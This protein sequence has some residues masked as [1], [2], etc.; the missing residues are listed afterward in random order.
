MSNPVVETMR[1]DGTEVAAGKNRQRPARHREQPGRHRKNRDGTSYGNAQVN[2]VRVP[3]TGALPERH[4]HSPGLRRGITGDD[5]ALPGS[6][7]GI[8]T[9]S[10]GGVTVYRGSAGT[11]PA[12]TGAQP[13]HYRRHPGLCRDAASFHRGTIV[14]NRGFTGINRN[15]A[16]ITHLHRGPYRPW[17]SYG[18]AQV[19]AVRVPKTGALPERHRHSPGLRRGITGDDRALP[20]S[21][22]GID[23]V[24][25]GGVT[26]YRGSA[27]TLP[28]FTGAQPE[29]Y[30]RHPGLCRDAASFHRGTIVD[31]RGFTGI[32]RRAAPANSVTAFKSFYE[33]S[34]Y[35]PVDRR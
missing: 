10:A 34:R 31:N 33:S 17:Q 23:T 35:S 30:R 9:V 11:L 22:A 5:R 19:N 6:D 14:D 4:R 7:A 12:F 27:G 18:N 24:S 1:S 3:K 2:A 13:E 15:L 8:D 25:A 21:D 16:D 20:G 26:V 32:N 29:H 28:A